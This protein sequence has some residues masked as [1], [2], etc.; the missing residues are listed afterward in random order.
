MQII[1]E[2]SRNQTT[3]GRTASTDFVRVEICLEADGGW[4]SNAFQ[5]NHAQHGAKVSRSQ[6]HHLSTRHFSDPVRMLFDILLPA[7]ARVSCTD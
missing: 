4:T 6:I 7:A 1:D 5:L 3:A 2:Q